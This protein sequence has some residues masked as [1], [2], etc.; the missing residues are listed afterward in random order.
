MKVLLDTNIC[1]YLIKNR[2]T[3][4]R[5]HFDRQMPG[6]VGVSAITVAEL[7]YGVAKSQAKARNAAALEMFLLPLE[8]LD[9]DRD[10][11]LTYGDVRAHLEK[12]GHP[13]GALD[14]L[15]AAQALSRDLTLVTNNLREFKRVPRLRC[16][17]WL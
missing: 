12:K 6:D 10:A 4:V 8:I 13:I 9:F 1:I 16:E 14:T 3:S 5:G 11:A 17:N 15:I 2:P 7:S